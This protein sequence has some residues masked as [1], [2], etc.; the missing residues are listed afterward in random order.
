MLASLDGRI[1]L[2]GAGRGSD[3]ATVG[4]DVADELL[5]RGGRDLLDIGWAP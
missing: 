1:V 4:R 3:P 2:R 5:E